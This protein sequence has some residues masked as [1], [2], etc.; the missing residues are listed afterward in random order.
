MH[1]EHDAI[2][3]GLRENR[4]HQPLA[5]SVVQRRVDGGCGNAEPAR[6]V[7][8]DIDKSLETALLQ[9]AGDIGELFALAQFRQ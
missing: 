9:I 4:R 1:F 8:V 7:A 2:L 6:R 5:K 3:I